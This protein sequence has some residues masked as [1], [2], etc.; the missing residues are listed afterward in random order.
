M[1]PLAELPFSFYRQ[2][3]QFKISCQAFSNPGVI[4]LQHFRQIA[5]PGSSVLLSAF[6]YTFSR[7]HHS[8]SEFLPELP[9]FIYFSGMR[10]EF[11]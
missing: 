8:F 5:Y 7:C 3:A 9:Q 1:L 11:G 2:V 6:S 4:C 10:V